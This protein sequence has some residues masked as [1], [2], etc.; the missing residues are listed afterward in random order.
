MKGIP[1]ETKSLAV[2]MRLSGYSLREI[3]THL[4]VSVA[5]L[6][7]LFR[8]RD[9]RLSRAQ[10]QAIRVRSVAPTVVDGRKECRKCGTWKLLSEYSSSSVNKTGV[11]SSCKACQSRYYRAHSD[12]IKE[13][14]RAWRERHPDRAY[15][16]RQV[17]YLRNRDQAIR[18]SKVWSDSNP[19]AKRARSA[20]RRARRRRAMPG[21]LSKEQRRKILEIYKLCP[22]GYVVD[23][24]V[25]LRA[26]DPATGKEVAC[27][28]H[29]PW[30][31]QYL[32][33]QE[34]SRKSNKLEVE[35]CYQ[36]RRR[37]ETE[38]DDR[39]AGLPFNLRANQF[40]LACEPFGLEHARF[41]RRYEW[42]GQVG[43]GVR[44]C[45]TARYDGRL[46]GVVL[47]SEPTAYSAF[48]KDA[49]ALVQRGACASWAPK[50]LNSRL[51]MFACRWMVNNTKKR[52][53][54]AYADH[55]AGEI[56]TIYQACNFDYLG[57]RF[58]VRYGYALPSGKI[59][60]ARYFTRTSAMKRWAKQLGIQW[61]AEWCKPNGFQD[62]SAYPEDVRRQL[63]EK[64][65]SEMAKCTKVSMS[66][67]SKYCLLLGKDRREQKKLNA[68]KTWTPLPYP[69]RSS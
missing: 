39:A 22:D 13:R 31:L 66:A 3:S 35:V 29:V 52:L 67:K 43:F 5:F 8:E 7:K 30:N 65:K 34:N 33:R 14:S 60:G 44:W 6:E 12:R 68:L 61:R 18:D 53:F 42:L 54:V 57:S 59:V 63:D 62:V 32:S 16:R 11:Q 58:G 45:F 46:A 24:I 25:P 2:K 50:N 40:S 38:L 1:N 28:L 37:D 51:V 21:W 19:H 15:Q 26:K 10:R 27:G 69:K 4:S 64:A 48:G 41:I 47:M 23:H 9:V 36:K 56:G 20:S 55:S 49:E 17:E